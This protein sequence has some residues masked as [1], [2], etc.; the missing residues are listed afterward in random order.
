MK[1]I[2]I[3]FA[4]LLTNF[5]YCQIYDSYT[6][7]NGVKYN[8]KDTI[9]LNIGSGPG[10]EFLYF[11]IGGWAKGFALASD[12]NQYSKFGRSNSN[13]TKTFAGKNVRLKKILKDKDGRI[14]FV[15]TAKMGSNYDLKIEEAIQT[16]EIK[17][18]KKSENTA[19]QY[20]PDKYDKLKKLKE[21]RDNNTISEEEFQKEK[22]KVLSGV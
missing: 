6:A 22:E 17:D 16:C 21:L 12:A 8:L 5:S 19:A 20:Q 4:I 18:C 15:V 9:T 2:L 13:P 11:Q 1:N 7:S 10:G 3:L 14:T